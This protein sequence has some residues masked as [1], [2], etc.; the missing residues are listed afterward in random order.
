MSNSLSVVS[1]ALDAEDFVL[2]LLALDLL[3][4]Y[5]SNELAKGRKAANNTK[6][7]TM[8]NMRSRLLIVRDKLQRMQGAL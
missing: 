5:A 3:D 8:I 6:Q 7:A 1:N 4:R 2:L